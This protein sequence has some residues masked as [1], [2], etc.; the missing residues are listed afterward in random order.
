MYV[1]QLQ[2]SAPA[3]LMQSCRNVS[4]VLQNQSMLVVKRWW[5]C[6]HIVIIGVV[7]CAQLPK[8]EIQDSRRLGEGHGQ[9]FQ[10]A[11][12]KLASIQ[13]EA[14]DCGP[15]QQCTNTLLGNNYQPSQTP[16]HADG[17]RLCHVVTCNSITRINA[18]QAPI[19]A[20]MAKKAVIGVGLPS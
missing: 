15:S 16:F 14:P 9:D 13:F 11:I 18:A 20:V 3:F 1:S 2:T 7:P 8:T 12:A 17:L 5:L 4:G 10:L 19:F 6:L